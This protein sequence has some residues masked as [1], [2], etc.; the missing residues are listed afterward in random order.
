MQQVN[1][2]RWATWA[3]AG[4]SKKPGHWLIKQE[5]LR[6]NQKLP[7][8]RTSS[9]KT[10]VVFDISFYRQPAVRSCP[11]SSSSVYQSGA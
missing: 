7:S 11:P 8:K 3:S 4:A 2:S 5:G 1:G 10:S 9:E 6:H